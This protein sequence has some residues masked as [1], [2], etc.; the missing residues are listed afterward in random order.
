MS[1]RGIG[2]VLYGG[3]GLGKTSWA[4]QWAAL[5][6]LRILS[7]GEIGFEDLEMVGEVPPGCTNTVVDSFEELDKETVNS[8]EDILVVDSL[9]GVQNLVFDYVCRTEFSNNKEDFT[10]YWKGQRI[11]SPP[12]FEKWLNRL[13]RQL[14]AG[15]HVIIIGHMFT[16]SLPNTMGADYLSHVV[17]LDDGDKGGMRSVLMRWAP[18]VLFL[19]IDVAITRATEKGIGNER[20]IV[21]E[22][23]ADDRDQRFFY[24]TKAPGH[25]AKNKLQLPPVISAGGSAQ[26]A[27]NNFIAKLPATV[28][29][30]L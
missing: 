18:N 27:F 13:S 29:N 26:E 6:S 10:S 30:N 14:A 7:A 24:T 5:G 15:R 20:G 1:K 23:K 16:T 28:R 17:S 11:N 8:T 3:E 19:N 22:G 9:M 25:Q 2:V 21:F 4:L 12:V